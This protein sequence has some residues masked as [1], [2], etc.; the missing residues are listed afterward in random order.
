MSELSVKAMVSLIHGDMI[1]DMKQNPPN[2]EV[3]TSNQETLNKLCT[4]LKGRDMIHEH[5]NEI[6]VIGS[7]C[8]IRTY[9]KYDRSANYTLFETSLIK[10][11]PS[12]REIAVDYKFM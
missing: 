6:E 1:E 3:I 5:K 12:V 10:P 9:I 7:N 4:E 11:T 2:E 8:L